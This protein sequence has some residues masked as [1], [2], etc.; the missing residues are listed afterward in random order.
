MQNFNTD[1]QDIISSFVD[2]HGLS[3]GQVVAEIEKT[4]SSMLSQW[5]KQD[6]IAIFGDNRLAALGY[7][8]NAAKM[9]QVPIELST[10]RGWNTIKRILDKNLSDAACLESVKRYKQKEHCISWGEIIKKDNRNNFVVE[11]ELDPGDVVYAT[12]L[13]NHLGAHERNVVSV[14][15]NRA[16]H[17][18]RVDPVIENNTP[19]VN[20][21]V[22]RVS[23]YLVE[24][25]LRSKL[26]STFKIRCTKRYV[27][28]KSFVESNAFIPKPV[29]LGVSRELNEHIQVK[30]KKKKK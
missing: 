10:M 15:Q 5:H 13:S 18:R 21:L 30:V 19:R 8:H 17:I 23:K 1:Y 22:D 6:V 16:F 26:G 28:Q 3:R 24:G 9:I 7:Q 20:V 25:L 11:I 14:G 12:C 27:G 29:I 4:F 2:K